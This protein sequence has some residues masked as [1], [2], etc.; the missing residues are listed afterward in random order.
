MKQIFSVSVNRK[1]TTP[2]YVVV[3]LETI[4]DVRIICCFVPTLS[5]REWS[6]FPVFPMGI[7]IFQKY[8]YPDYKRN[9]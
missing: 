2:I 6:D 7:G 4:F 5:E 9:V 1:K 3:P 8:H